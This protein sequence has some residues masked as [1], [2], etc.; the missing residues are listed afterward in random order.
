[1]NKSINPNMHIKQNLNTEIEAWL[2]QGN[3]ITKIQNTYEQRLKAR[4]SHIVKFVS[5]EKNQ[6]ELK[7]IERAANQA[8]EAQ[9]QMLSQWLDAHKGRAKAL[10]QILGCAHS[11]I[12]QIKSATRPCT[13]ARFEEIYQAMKIVEA[14]EKYH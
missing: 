2:A 9:I 8:A 6:K 14:R 10:V 3:V 4:P 1:M 11:Y 13:K 5:P 7:K 12:S